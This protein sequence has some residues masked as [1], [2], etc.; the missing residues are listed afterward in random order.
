MN[1]FTSIVTRI[2]KF[3]PHAQPPHNL[4]EHTGSD[5][6]DDIT[7]CGAIKGEVGAGEV[8]G[9]EVD[10]EMPGASN[11]VARIDWKLFASDKMMLHGREYIQTEFLPKCGKVEGSYTFAGPGGVQYRWAM[12]AIGLRFPKLVTADEKT[13]IAEFHCPNYLISDQKSRLEVRA[14]GMEMLDCIVLTFAYVENKR[15][16]REGRNIGG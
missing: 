15:R 10:L 3:G 13:V 7:L 4:G 2:R 12:D 5:S 14:E 9:D 16:E 11:E 8:K 6:D 1:L